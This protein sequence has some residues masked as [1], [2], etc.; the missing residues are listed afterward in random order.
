MDVVTA[1]LDLASNSICAILTLIVLYMLHHQDRRNSAQRSEI[2]RMVREILR[3]RNG[4][5]E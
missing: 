3:G 2:E 1:I 4:S 5:Q